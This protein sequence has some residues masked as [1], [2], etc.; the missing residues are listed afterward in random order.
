MFVNNELRIV[1][2]LSQEYLYEVKPSLITSTEKTF[3]DAIKQVLPEGYFAQSQV[4]LATVINKTGDFRFQ[5]ELYRNIDIG[6]FDLN[7]K[8][9]LLIEIHDKTH[10]TSKRRERDLKVKCICEEA[11][12][13]LIVFWVEYGVDVEYIRK[14]LVE[15]I[16]QSKSPK[17]IAHSKLK[18]E[19]AQSQ[20]KPEQKKDTGGCYVATAI[21]GDYD[22]P[23]VWI[24][25]RYRDF[26]LKNK[27]YG[28]IFIKMYYGI[29]PVL[30]K[31]FGKKEWFSR[32]FH[33]LLDKKVQKLF[34]EG[35]SHLPYED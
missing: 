9:V 22:C 28:R 17:R 30:V 26:H 18:Q 24:L 29:S 15:G 20:Q 11:G 25:R 23:S 35:Y 2:K 4:N 13:P 31:S 14:R 19:G 5:N 8:P 10:K 16:E 32:I 7:Y 33:P 27:W 1:I 21:Y 12:I 34:N 3:F 6:V